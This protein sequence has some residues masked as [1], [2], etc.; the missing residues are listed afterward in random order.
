MPAGM[1][2]ADRGPAFRRVEADCP[3]ARAAAAD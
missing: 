1:V 3:E 2:D